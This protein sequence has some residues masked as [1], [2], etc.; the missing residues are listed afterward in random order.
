MMLIELFTPMGQLSEDQRREV[1]ERL[2]N[3]VTAHE[4]APT[5]MLE[6]ARALW[7]VIVHEPATWYSGGGPVQAAA[8]PRYF[9]RLSLPSDGSSLTPEVRDHYVS[10]VTRVLAATAADPDRFWR[11]PRAVVH[12]VDIPEH[13]FGAVGRSLGNADIIRMVM[14]DMGDATAGAVPVEPG[15]TTAVDPVCGMTVALDGAAI[16]LEHEGATY[17]FC[18]AGCR[19]IFADQLAGTGS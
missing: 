3:E 6:P 16:T 12:I 5:E 2:L 9:V 10:T 11:E 15:A 7:H 1:A 4:G 18:N 14:G 8:D 17:A 13:S 19:D